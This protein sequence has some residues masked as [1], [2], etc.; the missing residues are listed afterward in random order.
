MA[1]PQLP[2][3][4]CQPSTSTPSTPLATPLEAIPPPWHVRGDVYCI[5]FWSGSKTS[6]LP[7]HAFS[8]LEAGSPFAGGVADSNHVPRG[9][10]MIQIIRYHESPVGPYDEMLLVPGSF[11]WSGAGAAEAAGAGAGKTRRVGRSPRISRMYVSDRRACYN[12]RLNWNCPKHLARFV[13]TPGPNGAMS[14]SVYPHDAN[15]SADPLETKPSS[16]PFFQ[17]SF[18]PLRVA[19]VFPFATRWLSWL[20]LDTT[21]VMPPLPAGLAP[22][23]PGTRRWCSFVP[24]QYSRR[25]RLGWFDLAQPENT[26]GLEKSS[27]DQG[28]YDHFWPALGRWALGVKMEDAEVVFDMPQATWAPRAKL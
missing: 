22:E 1:S 6:S 28:A 17:A 26:A 25:T 5:S 12:G 27:A 20:G 4:P 2:S 13:W 9:L 11:G 14:V 8:P 18:S 24:Q 7:A 23:L 3:P 15:H 19:P 21:L 16:S 10:G